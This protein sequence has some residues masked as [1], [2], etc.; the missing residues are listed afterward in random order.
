MV[1]WQHNNYV[2]YSSYFQKKKK[3]KMCEMIIIIDTQSSPGSHKYTQNHDSDTNFI[4]W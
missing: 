1:V 3:K 4:T 2:D